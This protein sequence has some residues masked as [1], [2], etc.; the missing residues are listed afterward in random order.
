M[1]D[2]NSLPK[3]PPHTN[4]ATLSTDARN[5]R[6]RFIRHILSELDDPAIDRRINDWTRA[7]ENA[8]DDLGQHVTHGDWLAGFRRRKETARQHC[9]LQGDLA[10]DRPL[11]KGKTDAA[12]ALWTGSE[13]SPGSEHDEKTHILDQMLKF[14]SLPDLPSPNPVINHLVLCVAPYGTHLSGVAEAGG[15]RCI[16][17]P[18]VFSDGNAPPSATVLYGWDGWECESSRNSCASL[19]DVSLSCYGFVGTHPV[20][21]RRGHLCL[22]WRYLCLAASIRCPCSTRG[23]LYPSRPCSRAAP[24]L[25]FEC[26]PQIPATQAPNSV[27]L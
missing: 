2:R 23:D 1:E 17:T 19:P 16:F 13:T 22:N 10:R 14:S 7:I 18:S 8:L 24:S 12:S 4:S 9:Q 3:L 20:A 15:L 27:F 11:L 5:H 21:C 6:T 26:A 25:R